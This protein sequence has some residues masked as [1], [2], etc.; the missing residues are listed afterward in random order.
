MLL[1]DAPAVI[2]PCNNSEVED[3]SAGLVPLLSVAGA[4]LAMLLP[5]INICRAAHWDISAVYLC[6]VIFKTIS[7]HKVAIESIL[8]NTATPAH[9]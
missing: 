6:Y 1:T 2:K 3:T 5:F 8:P 4:L 9:I 7:I